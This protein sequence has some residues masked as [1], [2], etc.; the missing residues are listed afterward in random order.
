MWL[1]CVYERDNKSKSSELNS[2]PTD[3]RMTRCTYLVWPH[4]SPYNPQFPA[5]QMCVFAFEVMKWSFKEGRKDLQI[6]VKRTFD[7]FQG[8]AEQVIRFSLVFSGREATQ[9]AWNTW[10]IPQGWKQAQTKNQN[11]AHWVDIK[12]SNNIWVLMWLKWCRATG[13]EKALIC[14]FVP[15][16][17]FF[18][19]NSPCFLLLED[20]LKEQS[21]NQQRVS[22]VSVW[23]QKA[24]VFYHF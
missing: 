19:T 3:R 10:N 17:S 1:N 4:L 6:E 20:K 9:V 12:R 21:T 18:Q 11:D 5:L 24:P 7:A 15:L 8:F 14:V 13:G 2:A 23:S 22:E 16:H